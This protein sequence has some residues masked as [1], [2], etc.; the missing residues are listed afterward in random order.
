M[1]HTYPQGSSKYPSLTAMI[2][3]SAS[4]ICTTANAPACWK[5]PDC[6]HAG[7]NMKIDEH[8]CLKP[9]EGGVMRT[10]RLPTQ[11]S[12]SLLFLLAIEQGNIS[13]E[14]ANSRTPMRVEVTA[15]NLVIRPIC[16]VSSIPPRMAQLHPQRHVHLRKH[17]PVLENPARIAEPLKIAGTYKKIINNNVRNH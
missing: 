13:V 11:P 14:P 6:S 15:P 12:I 16:T 2:R 9:F 8:N 4:W 3:T 7:G 10:L 1:A 17:Q 5:S